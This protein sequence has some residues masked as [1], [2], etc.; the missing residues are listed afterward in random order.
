LRLQEFLDS[1]HKKVVKF[2][3][4]STGRLYP[5]EISL[6]FIYVT[7]WVEPRA[8]A[9]PEELS[10]WK[11]NPLGIEHTTFWLVAQCL[12]LSLGIL[13][14]LK[15]ILPLS[16]SLVGKLYGGVK[17]WLF[18]RPRNAAANTSIPRLDKFSS[19]HYLPAVGSESNIARDSAASVGRR[20][21]RKSTS[22]GSASRRKAAAK[23]R[24]GW[25]TPSSLSIHFYFS[26]P[27]LSTCLL[28]ER[29]KISHSLCE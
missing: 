10:K 29:C 17:I 26:L 3:V 11:I 1:W 6:I 27:F 4:L 15:D 21:V 12:T 24:N 23:K 13:A 18:I 9:R 16:K 22:H 8:I 25:G 14:E 5:Q 2:P 7:G 20:C 19:F 28:Y